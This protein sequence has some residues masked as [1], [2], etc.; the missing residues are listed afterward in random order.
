MSGSFS[1]RYQVGQFYDPAMRSGQYAR[2]P[3]GG[4][5][6]SAPGA[7]PDMGVRPVPGI[8][9]SG[10]AV[11]P[12]AGVV[13]AAGTGTGDAGGGM[14][15]M[16]LASALGLL[17]YV[18]DAINLVGRLAGGGAEEALPLP[19]EFLTE[20]QA[21]A[22][23]GA[24]TVGA[25]I[26]SGMYPAGAA[27]PAGQQFITGPSGQAF[28][29]PA[30]A[31]MDIDG[32][33][34]LPDGSFLDATSWLDLPGAGSNLPLAPIESGIVA[35]NSLTELAGGGVSGAEMT[36]VAAP[37]GG[38]PV[39]IPA[40]AVGDPFYGSLGD[41]P[42]FLGGG[43]FATGLAGLGGGTVGG[44]ISAQAPWTREGYGAIGQQAGSAAGGIAAGAAM[45]SAFGPIGTFFGALG[46]AFLGGMAGG[47]AGSM[48]GPP[49][50]VGPNYGALGRFNAQGGI[51]F[52]GFGADNGGDPADAQALGGYLSQ[53]LPA[54]AQQR[55]LMF[56][57]MAAGYEISAGG[58]GD[59]GMFYLPGTSP[60]P[61]VHAAFS[62]DPNAYLNIALGDLA[63]RGVY[64]PQG[65]TDFAAPFANANA[66]LPMNVYQG[67]DPNSNALGDL[68]RAATDTSYEGVFGR[69]SAAIDAWNATNQRTAAEQQMRT[70]QQ[71]ALM[72]FVQQN[73]GMSLA[74]QG[75]GEGDYFVQGYGPINASMFAP[76]GAG[77]F[78][79]QA[80]TYSESGG[81]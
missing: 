59:R 78:V 18:P 10:V 50:T 2:M 36:S 32:I 69:Q 34:Q 40:G 55:G 22:L 14:D 38:A 31:V 7:A 74:G 4:R 65:T 27:L 11:R 66:S 19:P 3:G 30:G 17:P 15:A 21:A 70:G 6:P 9:A 23:N 8:D 76:D 71:N 25:P 81:G 51:D 24:P 64:V 29:L 43:D 48:I 35:P 37:T 54:Y 68:V 62:R 53:A 60:S 56:N 39:G 16:I 46:G 12:G 13:T 57:P 26:T 67:F 45:G 5:A 28:T 73:N 61:E 33:V 47:G 41:M 75:G 77:Q 42:S 49:P 80:P 72:Q 79:F 52:I 63:A 20:E 58:Y 44:L 1:P